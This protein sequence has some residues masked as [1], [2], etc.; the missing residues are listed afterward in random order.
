[1]RAP[2]KIAGSAPGNS[3]RRKI[4]SA[5]AVQRPHHPDELGVGRAQ[6]VHGVDDDREE[7]DDRDD[8]QLRRQSRSRAGS[9]GSGRA[10]TVGTVCESTRIGSSARRSAAEKWMQRPRRRARSPPPAGTRAAPRARV[11]RVACAS[12]PKSSAEGR[13]RRRSAPGRGSPARPQRARRAPRRRRLR[14]AGTSGGPDRLTRSPPAPRSRR[15]T[16]AGSATSR[17]ADGR[18]R[19]RRRAR[20]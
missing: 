16:N 6:P 10:R 18:V 2:E 4:A 11:T 7:A 20:R 14:R 19:C 5:S 13:Q 9:R 15:S 12:R 17:A 1:M 3:T 8:D